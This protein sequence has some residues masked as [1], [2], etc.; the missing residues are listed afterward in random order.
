MQNSM[1]ESPLYLGKNTGRFSCCSWGA[2]LRI[3]AFYLENRLEKRTFV[4]HERT[5]R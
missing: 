3:L 5:G 4:L 2:C 1:E